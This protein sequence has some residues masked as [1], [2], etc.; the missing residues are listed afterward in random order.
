MKIFSIFL[1][2][3]FA[4]VFAYSEVKSVYFA[5]GCFWCVEEAFEK[6]DGVIEVYS[7]Y[8]GGDTINPTYT[9]VVQG[10]TGHIEAVK[11]DYHSDIVSTKQ[12]LKTLFL[13]I[14]PF[15]GG[16]QFCDRGYSYKSAVFSNDKDLLNEAQ[17]LIK[18]IE[19]NHNNKVEVL[20]LPY[21]NFYLAE[22]YHQNYY[23]KNPLRYTYYK[24]S[25]G[26]EQRIKQ[27]QINLG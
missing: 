21:K 12:L 11:I 14:D 8:S 25:C 27:L 26:R 2:I 18:T 4:P 23:D 7:G 6:I 5:G 1:M 9:E 17:N 13:N 22:D 3:M 16:G 20:I 10:G 19:A 24:F 15:D